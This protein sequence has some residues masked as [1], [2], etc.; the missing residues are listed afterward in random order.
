MK[1][2]TPPVLLGGIP[3]FL[4]CH[5][6]SPRASM[7]IGFYIGYLISCHR[8]HQITR[9][10][11]TVT[12][13]VLALLIATGAAQA[14][15]LS[16][17]KVDDPSVVIVAAT[18]EIIPGDFDRLVALLQGLPPSIRTSFALDSPGGN[19]VEA[20]KIAN[21]IRRLHATVG[22]LGQS[23]CVSACFLVFAAGARKLVQPTAL[24]GVHSAS[25]AGAENTGTLAM[26]TA[27]ARDAAA[28]GV[29][30]EIIGKMVIAEPGQMEWLTQR[31]L[32]SMGVTIL[33]P[34]P[35]APRIASAPVPP[36]TPPQAAIP[37]ATAPP[38]ADQEPLP[39]REGL[40][41]RQRWEQWYATLSGRYL[42]GASF[43]SAHRSDR[44]PPSC[45]GNGG[46]DLGAFT[47]GCSS[48]QQRLA[49]PD[50]RRKAEPDYRR[51]WNSY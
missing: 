11:A 13:L 51:G 36:V 7:L 2:R 29:P 37:P 14:M 48:A 3:T 44:Q 38:V 4:A 35:P 12:C 32:A 8:M 41:D 10:A 47:A 15:Q 20:E 26:T 9:L 6:G 25:I 31:D 1:F 30:P 42:E 24:I 18:G 21:V 46:L 39:F 49:T 22:V 50:L 33:Q 23:K 40:A 17:I 27:M 28:L 45:H 34:D 19:V 16:T 43:W 5:G